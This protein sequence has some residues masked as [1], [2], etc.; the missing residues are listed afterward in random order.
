MLKYEHLSKGV[1]RTKKYIQ[2]RN[3]GTSKSLITSKPSLNKTLMDGIDWN[4]IITIGGQSGSGKSTILEELKRDFCT[5]NEIDFNILSFE[6]EMLIEDQLARSIS[7]KVNRSVKELYTKDSN[8]DG[9]M[10]ALDQYNDM[11]IYFVDNVGSVV[12]IRETIV[13][14]VQKLCLP[15][16]KNVII[17][18]DHLLLTKG[19]RGDEE[20]DVIDDL[21]RTFVELKKYISSLG[22]KCL[23]VSLSQLNR[24]IENPERI[25]NPLLHYPNKN[26]L[27]AASSTY[28]CSDYVIITHR[29]ATIS[30]ITRYYGPPTKNHKQGLPLRSSNN[31]DL[32][33]WHVIKERF[34]SNNIL[35]MEEDFKYSRLN[36]YDLE[37]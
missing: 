14:F 2:E 32:I 29:P 35:V 12:D 16:G 21:M 26:D 9:V 20:K 18:L 23:F 8:I 37:I 33:Y 15:T 6:F 25:L 22:I 34:G 24:N 13:D 11:P 28:Y 7:P 5:L 1:E 17:T 30:G 36:E 31:K 19:K 3:D 27:F 10:D 4:R